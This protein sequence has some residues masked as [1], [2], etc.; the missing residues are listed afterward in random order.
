MN[1][2]ANVGLSFNGDCE[3][4]FKLYAQLFEAKLEL[5]LTWGASPLADKAPRGW[6]AKILFARLKGRTMTLTG[7]DVLPG[8]YQAPTGFNLCLSTSAAAEA[9]RLFAELATGGS[10]RMPLETT[11]YAER[12]GEVV[13]RFGVPWEVRTR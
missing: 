13:D 8:T 7:A 2:E 10:V 6:A 11:F 3:A 4:A 1:L 5:V 12:Y 9:E